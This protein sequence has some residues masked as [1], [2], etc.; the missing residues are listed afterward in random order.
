M[1]YL[2]ALKSHIIHYKC[3]SY[4]KLQNSNSSMS[5]ITLFT[6][7][8]FCLYHKVNSPGTV[9]L[10]KY[11]TPASNPALNIQTHSGGSEV[12]GRKPDSEKTLFYI[13]SGTQGG[14]GDV[15]SRVLDVLLQS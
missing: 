9:T 14:L 4:T 5:E 11:L 12:R 6:Y 2:G 8:V 15:F 3:I 1:D 13:N 7:T 10:L